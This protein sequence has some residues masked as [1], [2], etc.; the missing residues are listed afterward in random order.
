MAKNKTIYDH[1]RNEFSNLNEMCDSW[2]I[3]T[4]TYHD[5]K[6]KGWSLK[7]I[8]ETKDKVYDLKS[9]EDEN[10][11]QK[12]DQCPKTLKSILK[13]ISVYDFFKV[14]DNVDIDNYG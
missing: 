10:S 11:N 12:D 6:S 3:S 2:G 8:L 7:K 5:R 9:I 1:E 14:I 4:C 13:N